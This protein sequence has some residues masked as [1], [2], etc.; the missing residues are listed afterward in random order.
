MANSVDDEI[1]SFDSALKEVVVC[2]SKYRF[3]CARSLLDGSG[4]MRCTPREINCENDLGSYITFCM[5]F[6]EM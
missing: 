6:Y 1:V 4:Y 3:I 2:V 5:F